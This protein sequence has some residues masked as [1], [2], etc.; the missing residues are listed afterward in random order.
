MVPALA[1]VEPGRD[2]FSI[3]MHSLATLHKLYLAN[4]VA[5][6]DRSPAQFLTDLRDLWH[7]C[8]VLSTASEHTQW[9]CFRPQLPFC[10]H[11]LAGAVMEGY[12][13]AY[14]QFSIPIRFF[15]C[16]DDRLFGMRHASLHLAGQPDHTS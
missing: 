4:T 1:I 7:R 11:T 2:I 8:F 12:A 5:L 10:L 16:A 15:A 13:D 14:N 6:Y 9:W 3:V